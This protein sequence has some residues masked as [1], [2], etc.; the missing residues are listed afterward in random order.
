[1]ATAPTGGLMVLGALL[2]CGGIDE[3]ARA[4]H[5]AMCASQPGF[6]QTASDDAMSKLRG[7]ACRTKLFFVDCEDWWKRVVTTCVYETDG[8]RRIE[9]HTDI[10]IDTADTRRLRNELCDHVRWD[11]SNTDPAFVYSQRGRKKMT[12][13]GKVSRPPH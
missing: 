8:A 5:R 12:T 9:V 4:D 11:V 6:D 2:A 13:C 7:G 10:S 3:S 1:M